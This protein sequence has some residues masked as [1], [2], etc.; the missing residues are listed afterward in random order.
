VIDASNPARLHQIR[1]YLLHLLDHISPGASAAMIWTGRILRH[2]APPNFHVATVR[3]CRRVAP[4]FLRLE[5]DCPGAGIMADAKGMHFSLL[6][7]P[8]GRDP[9]WPR[10]DGDGRTRLPQAAD[11]LHRAVY[12]FVTLDPAAGRFSFDVFEHAGGRATGWA[13]AARPGDV[14]GVMGPGSG[15]FP[16][17]DDLLMAGDE[18][19]LPAIRRI[20]E[21]SPPQRRGDVFVELADTADICDLRRPDGMRLTWVLRDRGE[22]LWDYLREQPAPD[23]G[24]R[25]VWI[26]AEKELVRKAKARFRGQLGIRPDESYIA[27]YWSAL[28]EPVEQ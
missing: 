4:R 13:R 19:A 7:P 23:G 6:L 15:D 14:I 27:Y 20:L 26:G 24:C 1:E 10:L 21:H 8:E 5:V 22:T 17:G 2:A 11:G 28:E 9:V 12:T 25:F 18:T 3:S 16:P